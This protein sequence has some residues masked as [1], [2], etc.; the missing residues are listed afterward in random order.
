[1]VIDFLRFFNREWTRMG[2]NEREEIQAQTDGANADGIR[3][4]MEMDFIKFLS[5]FILFICG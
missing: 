4:F 5:E 2:A 3:D 1:M